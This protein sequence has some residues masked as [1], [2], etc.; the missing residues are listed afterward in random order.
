MGRWKKTQIF[1]PTPQKAERKTSSKNYQ[2]SFRDYRSG[3]DKSPGNFAKSKHSDE[4][5]QKQFQ[6]D[7]NRIYVASLPQPDRKRIH[8]KAKWLAKVLTI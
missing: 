3:G 5:Y 6:V 1:L 4:Q 2:Q 7:M 8:K